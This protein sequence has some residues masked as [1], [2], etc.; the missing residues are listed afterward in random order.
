MEYSSGIILYRKD[1]DGEV[2]FLMCTPG[3]PYWEHKYLWSFP[4][5]HIEVNETP[6]EAAIREFIEETS[7]IINNNDDV[8]YIDL[9]KQNSNKKVYVFAKRYSGEKLENMHSNTATSLYHG[10]YIIY[11]E[12]KEYRWMTI[13]ELEKDGMQCYIPIYQK[14]IDDDTSYKR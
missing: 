10:N 9:V 14:I 3:G 2:R 11:P 7:I 12:V 5:G 4:K 6:I 8:N 13:H 1:E